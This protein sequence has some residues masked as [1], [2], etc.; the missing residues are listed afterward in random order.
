MVKRM[1][2]LLDILFNMSSLIPFTLFFE[3]ALDEGK[4]MS[5]LNFDSFIIHTFIVNR[6][7][8]VHFRVLKVWTWCGMTRVE[9]T[10]S[11]MCCCFPFFDIVQVSNIANEIH[12]NHFCKIGVASRIQLLKDARI[13]YQI[14]ALLFHFQALTGSST[15]P[16]LDSSVCFFP[17]PRFNNQSIFRPYEGDWSPRLKI[18]LFK[19]MATE[20]VISTSCGL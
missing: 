5:S 15:L 20:A 17:V 10:F 13:G 1:P 3:V 8:N 11:I 16:L 6:A 12:S 7:S 2:G 19:S 18:G 4:S 9:M 14:L